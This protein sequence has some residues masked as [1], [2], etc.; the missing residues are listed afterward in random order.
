MAITIAVANQKGGVG[1]TT[2]AVNIAGVL[3]RNGNHTLLID[4]DPQ[5]NATTSLGLK[6]HALHMTVYEVLAGLVPAH[7]AVQPTGRA[8][9]SVIPATENL[10]GSE[11]ELAQV[12]RREWRLA[13]SLADLSDFDYILI[14]TLS[15]SGSER[16]CV[17]QA[18]KQCLGN[19]HDIVLGA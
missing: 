2:T 17:S 14:S 9:Y 4:L 10:A 12:D 8:Q 16:E 11:I 18:F 6:K 3:A 19:Y 13:E 5:G 15:I 1:K 7:A